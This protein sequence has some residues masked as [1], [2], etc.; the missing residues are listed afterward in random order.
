M[1]LAHSFREGLA[2]FKRA[3]FA[4]FAS[5][6]AIVVALTLL[7]MLGLLGYHAERVMSW[8]QQEASE[9]EV[10]LTD[11][12]EAQRVHLE[13]Q[14]NARPEVASVDFISREEALAI[15]QEE[16]GSEGSIFSDGSF[17][18]ASFK[19]KL[20]STYAN[21]D[22]LSTSAAWIETLPGVEEVIFN[23]PLMAQVQRNL[24]MLVS[25]AGGIGVLVLLAALFLIGN[26]IRLT[27]YA[28]RLL[29]R[30]M[31][32]VGATN[33]FI[34]RP[35]VIEGMLQGLTGGLLAAGIVWGVHLLMVKYVP[36]FSFTDWPG[37]SPWYVV[38]LLA[39]AGLLL[40]WFGSLI[41]AQRFIRNVSLH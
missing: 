10:F 20:L 32:L 23:Q 3:K 41:A 40:G 28:R 29:I 22:A 13:A 1:S 6:S 18:P 5:T 26:T 33:A 11:E 31:K 9:I 27:I 35:F 21:V 15:F 8:L 34:R 17:L 16:F 12:G 2:G 30:T 38:S 37:G 4:A 25:V 19:V 24:N 39:G 36:G 7:G 14:I